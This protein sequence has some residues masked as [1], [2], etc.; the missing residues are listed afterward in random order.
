MPDTDFDPL[1]AKVIAATAAGMSPAAAAAELGISPQTVY[2]VLRKPLVRLALIEARAADV[3]PLVAHALAEVNKSIAQLVRVRDGETTRDADRIRASTAVLDWF[4]NVYQMGE[5]GPR[6][7]SLEAQLAASADAGRPAALQT[8]TTD[9][10]VGPV[11]PAGL[12]ADD[13]PLTGDAA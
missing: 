6:L 4:R 3:R 7:A 9:P 2:R 13:L 11:P 1:D 5:V 12:L 8:T 10:T